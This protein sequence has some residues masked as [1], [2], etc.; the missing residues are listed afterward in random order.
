MALDGFSLLT[1]GVAELFR[2]APSISASVNGSKTETITLGGSVAL[3]V[4]NVGDK[5]YWGEFPA[6]TFRVFEGTLSNPVNADDDMLLA[7]FSFG[8]GKT[9][10]GRLHNTMTGT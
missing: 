1:R 9:K 5:R 6:V 7:A 4:K 3:R 10:E 8:D 2:G